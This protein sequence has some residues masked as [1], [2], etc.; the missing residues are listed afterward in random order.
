MAWRRGRRD[1]SV[2]TRRKILISTQVIA[3]VAIVIILLILLLSLGGDGG[4]QGS[5][6]NTPGYCKE[7]ATPCM[8][9]WTD[10]TINGC[11]TPQEYCTN[12]DDSYH[13]CCTTNDCQGENQGWCRCNAGAPPKQAA[14]GECLNLDRTCMAS[15]TDASM[16]GTCGSQ[17]TACSADGSG[18]ACDGDSPW[19][20]LDEECDGEGSGW[21]YC[22]P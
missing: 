4:N 6:H 20:C 9:S 11:G 14:S 15:W 19:C 8:A 22:K 18:N 16:G 17:Q 2:R 7:S 21:C 12:C 13:W 1:D 10:P 5:G 3:G